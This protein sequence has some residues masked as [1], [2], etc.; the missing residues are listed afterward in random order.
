VDKLSNVASGQTIT[1]QEAKGQ[2]SSRA[3]GTK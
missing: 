3:Y 2:I 1:I